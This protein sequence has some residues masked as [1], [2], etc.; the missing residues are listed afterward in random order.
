MSNKTN[1]KKRNAKARAAERKA[2]N[3][4]VDASGKP[5]S[6]N[7]WREMRR[8]H[9]RIK[10]RNGVLALRGIGRE[11]AK[12]LFKTKALRRAAP[13]FTFRRKERRRQ[14][15]LDLIHGCNDRAIGGGSITVSTPVECRRQR[16]GSRVKP[17]THGAAPR[18]SRSV[19]T[20]TPKREAH[21]RIYA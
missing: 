19:K 20:G 12:R 11:L 3:R 7:D 13:G 15:R 6:D 9:K 17:H 8:A 18:K 14:R 4:P 21:K 2:A 10:D 1:K 16:R 5:V